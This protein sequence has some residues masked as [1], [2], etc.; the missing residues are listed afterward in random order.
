MT[1][2]NFHRSTLPPRLH[3]FAYR[4]RHSLG[5]RNALIK[6]SSALCR[7]RSL[8][9]HHAS[10]LIENEQRQTWHTKKMKATFF[11]KKNANSEFI[12]GAESCDS[13]IELVTTGN[14][15][16]EYIATH[17]SIHATDRSGCFFL[18][19]FQSGTTRRLFHSAPCAFSVDTMSSS[20][21][22]IRVT[23]YVLF[24]CDGIDATLFPAWSFIN[25]RER[26]NVRRN[27]WIFS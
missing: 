4:V 25:Q 9:P 5:T 2:N 13:W 3:S 18:F 8:F 12:R 11:F 6:N 26:K 1:E 27:A 24:V 15:V 16:E 17:G 20:Q 19:D 21:W 10:T 22:K 7:R 14:S 23:C